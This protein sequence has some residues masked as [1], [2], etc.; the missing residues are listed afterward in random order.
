MSSENK[1]KVNKN[2]K[3]KRFIFS[4][5]FVFEA[6]AQLRPLF[7]SR[8][9]DHILQAYLTCRNFFPTQIQSIFMAM[10]MHDKSSK[11][12]R[13]PINSVKYHYG[14][15]DAVVQFGNASAT[16]TGTKSALVIALIGESSGLFFGLCYS[17][18]FFF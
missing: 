1:K 10:R 14:D 3:N 13:L 4:E 15:A 2:P 17:G 5:R 18:P 7:S 16:A 11:G 8:F 6:E 12:P 9:K